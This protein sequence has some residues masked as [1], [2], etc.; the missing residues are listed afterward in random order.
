MIKEKARTE[1]NLEEKI[2]SFVSEKQPVHIGEI[3]KTLRISQT[4]G[5]NYVTSMINQGKL[6]YA[7]NNQVNVF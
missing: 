1:T 4:K 3:F 5:L 6:Y 2:I 7:S